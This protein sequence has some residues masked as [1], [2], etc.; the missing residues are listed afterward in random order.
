MNGLKI[1]HVIV[2]VGFSKAGVKEHGLSGRATTENN[3]MTW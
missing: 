3:C 1:D 2:M